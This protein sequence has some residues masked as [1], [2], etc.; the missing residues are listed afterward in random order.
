MCNPPVRGNRIVDLK[1]AIG[2]ARAALAPRVSM[3]TFIFSVLI[4]KS[5]TYHHACFAANQVDLFSSDVKDYCFPRLHAAAFDMQHDYTSYFKE[6]ITHHTSRNA[7][8]FW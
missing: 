4:V 8:K 1:R 3:D 7:L 5:S 6:W 2:V